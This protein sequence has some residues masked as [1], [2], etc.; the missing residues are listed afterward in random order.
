MKKNSAFVDG[1][2]SAFNLYPSNKKTKNSRSAYIVY[3]EHQAKALESARFQNIDIYLGNDSS[4][5]NAAKLVSC[6]FNNS[7][8]LVLE[9][10]EPAKKA[11]VLE[12]YSNFT[13]VKRSTRV[14][15]R[16]INSNRKIRLAKKRNPKSDDENLINY[17]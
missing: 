5:N 11:E 14:R 6:Y 1:F 10:L 15:S 4:L 16:I 8:Q 17:A 2:L 3:R 13:P 7:I 12:L 9:D